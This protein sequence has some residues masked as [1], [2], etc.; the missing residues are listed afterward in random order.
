[1]LLPKEL[2]EKLYHQSFLADFEDVK[3]Y[4]KLEN[5]KGTKKTDDIIVV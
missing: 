1:M 5:T 2:M 3:V 4:K